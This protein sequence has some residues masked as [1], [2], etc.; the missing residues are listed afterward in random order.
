MGYD[1]WDVDINLAAHKYCGDYGTSDMNQPTSYQE[2]L[3]TDKTP[4]PEGP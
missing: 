3:L 4:T 1:N 2:Y